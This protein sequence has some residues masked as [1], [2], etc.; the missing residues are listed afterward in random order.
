MQIQLGCLTRPWHSFTPEEALAGIAAAGFKY[1]GLMLGSKGQPLI[2]P[3]TGQQ[4]IARVNEL[5]ERHGLI[6]QVTISN[7]DTTL[8]KAEAVAKLKRTISWCQGMHLPYLVLTGTHDESK[9]EAWYEATGEALD[10]AK[11]AGVRVLLKAH[12]GMCA[13]A[14]D[15]LY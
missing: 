14:E 8:P 1:V 7:T 13:L 11:E 5:V 10:Y 6:H 15:L 12:G 9:Y 4:D 3:E 2:S